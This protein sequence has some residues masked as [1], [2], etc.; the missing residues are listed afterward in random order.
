MEN[1]FRLKKAK[2]VKTKK[3]SSPRTE[4]EPE[5]FE[6]EISAVGGRSFRANIVDD[7]DRL[8]CNLSIVDATDRLHI[9]NI[10]V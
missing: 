2:N 9:E 8:L 4:F 5:A 3:K 7:V 6:S 1:Y 10:T